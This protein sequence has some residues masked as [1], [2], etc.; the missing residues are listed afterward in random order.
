MS[1]TISFAAPLGAPAADGTVVVQRAAF[2]A[3]GDLY[4]LGTKPPGKAIECEPAG[5]LTADEVRA[6]GVQLAEESISARFRLGA[7]ITIRSP[8]DAAVEIAIVR[9]VSEVFGAERKWFLGFRVGANW[10]GAWFSETDLG[11][12]IE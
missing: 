3:G 11:A 5:M 9:G 2:G 10:R 7:A 1:G 4:R 6:R 8:G 12:A